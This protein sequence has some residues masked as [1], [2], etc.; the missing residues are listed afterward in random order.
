M[1]IPIY[2]VDAFTH[3]PFGGNPA[4]VCLLPRPAEA[5]WMQN[6]AKEMNLSETAFLY[7]L[8]DGYNLRWFT[9]K[10]EIDLCGHAT[11][12]SAHILWE[13]GTLEKGVR[14]RFHTRSGLLTAELHDEWIELNFPS[15]HAESMELPH[16]VAAALGISPIYA[17]KFNSDYLAEVESEEIVRSIKP[18]FT[19]LRKAQLRAVIVTAKSNSEEFD[20]VSRFFAP[21]AGIDED[22]VTGSAHCI[23]GPY[24]EGKLGKSSFSAYQASER[25]GVLRVKVEGDRVCMAGQA[26]TVFKG[27]LL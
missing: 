11:L 7:K 26:V 3:K 16:E 23:L 2:Q 19:L 22:P 6:V 20:F 27:E 21:G 14:A 10:I 17:A 4:A 25:G 8:E 9:P 1:G 12:A 18:D 5:E 15:R 24:W 13:T